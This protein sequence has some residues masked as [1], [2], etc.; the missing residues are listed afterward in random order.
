[1]RK[2]PP[3]MHNLVP[4]H[5]LLSQEEKEKFLSQ[6]RISPSNLPRIR[7]TDPALQLFGIKAK[8]SDIIKITR[9]EPTGTAAHY[10]AVVE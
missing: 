4:K 6:L 7:S 9:S 1:M 2:E 5:E 3:L 8:A 10:R